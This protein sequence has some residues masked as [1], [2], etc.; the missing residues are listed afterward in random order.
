[1]NTLIC[2]ASGAFNNEECL[3][4]AIRDLRTHDFE[5]WHVSVLTNSSENYLEQQN[6][7]GD[8]LLRVEAKDKKEERKALDIL[9]NHFAHDIQVHSLRVNEPKTA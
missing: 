1:M 2:E 5:C 6:E 7:C 8:L 9:S 3:M 4:G